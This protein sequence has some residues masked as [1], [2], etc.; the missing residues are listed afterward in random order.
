M[1][2]KIF[3][4]NKTLNA[5]GRFIDLS[6]PK[7]MGILNV[8]S[9][10]F[11]EGSRL[12]TVED[13]LQRAE[14]MVLEGADFLDVGGYSSRPGATDISESEELKRVIP[15]IE[16]LRKKLPDVIISIDTFRSEV[17]QAA[18]YAGA[19][20][21]N[22]I[23]GGNGDSNMYS[24]AAHAK[25]PYVLMHMRGTPQTMKHETEYDDLVGEMINYFHARLD[26]LKQAGVKDVI[27]DPGFGFAK[28]IKQNFELLQNL[29]RFRILE[30][31]LLVGLSRKSMIWRT[32][33]TTP[34]H[35]L[36]GTSVVN[37]IALLKGASILRV[38]DVRA[39]REAIT[40]TS[41]LA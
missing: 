31:P 13:V 32:L 20:M 25:A 29:Q 16:A 17:A 40:L 38:H 11:Y 30:K 14:I 26:R 39:A 12:R 34:E 33:E 5:Q 10:S 8:T 21:I 37:T 28:T 6:A 19:D 15:V 27:I 35:A 24:V 23:T 2:S 9:D 3:S 1:Q 18:L 41:Q 36:N 7:V 4:A 22:D